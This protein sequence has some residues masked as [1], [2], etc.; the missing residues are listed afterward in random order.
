M[1]FTVLKACVL[2]VAYKGW[3]QATTIGGN[4]IVLLRTSYKA[5]TS[6]EQQA[7]KTR[8]S[9]DLMIIIPETK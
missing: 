7:S 1:Y 8:H 3:I 6:D 5:W 2:G 9:D 4:C